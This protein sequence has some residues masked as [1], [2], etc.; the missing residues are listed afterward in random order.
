MKK[1]LLVAVLVMG[2][3]MMAVA[4]DIPATEIFAGY[5]YFRCTTGT[6]SCDLNGWNLS[7]A[8][9][10]NKNFAPVIDIGGHYG[11]LTGR[12]YSA[13]SF[14]AGP[15][16]MMPVGRFTPF[17]HFLAGIDHSNLGGMKTRDTQ[18][19]FALAVGGGVDISVNSFMSVR[20]FQ[21]E[22]YG[23]RLRGELRHD[24]R[25]AAG[26]IFKLGKRY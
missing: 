7:A 2:F 12:N 18:N 23:L 25:V 8:F 20:A 11:K 10:V 19:N 1:F 9:N 3:S 13:H 24:M 22:Y 26:A 15:K 21:A 6:S 4:Q 5:S 14:M 17:V 16:F